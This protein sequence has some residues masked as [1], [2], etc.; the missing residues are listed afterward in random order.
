MECPKCPG[1]LESK[2]YGRKITVHRC[3]ECAGLWC[4]PAVLLEM[5]KEWMSEAILDSGNPSV[6]EKLNKIDQIKCPECAVDMQKTSD[7]RQ[8]HIWYETCPKCEGMFF[9]A[10]EFSDLKYDTFMDRIRDLV[11]GKRPNA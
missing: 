10:G 11:R 6:G 7:S 9:D 2:T 8:T 1:T 3:S 5:K 4:K